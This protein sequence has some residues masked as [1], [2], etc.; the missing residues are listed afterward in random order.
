MK[1]GIV[2]IAFEKEYDQCAAHSAVHARKVTDLPIH[3]FTNLKTSDP[4][5]EKVPGV[6]F[7]RFPGKDQL[8][9]RRIKLA[10]DQY[11]PFDET[12]HTDADT[13]IHSEK[14]MEAFD[15]LQGCDI[16][17][18]I[19]EGKESE[20]R[21]ETKLYIRAIRTWNPT[22]PLFVYQGGVF[23]FKKNAAVRRF[24]SDWME[25]WQVYSF[26]DMPPLMA[27]VHTVKD[28][29]VG[30][31]PSSMGFRNSEVIQHFF[32]WRPPKNKILPPFRKW[33]PDERSMRWKWDRDLRRWR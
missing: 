6:T 14:F 4:L 5:W 33:N 10:L 8:W 7:Q 9:T 30:I 11:S 31:L 20:W 32:G 19:H 26:R 21:L 2:Y 12:L 1:R 17:F 15:I 28:V 23:V 27:T 25:K 22:P 29:I 24:F 3:V 13:A 16:A 18:P